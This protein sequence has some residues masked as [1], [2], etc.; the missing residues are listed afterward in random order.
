[1]FETEERAPLQ[2]MWWLTVGA[3]CGSALMYLFDPSRGKRR[4]TM[5]RDRAVH[6]GHVAADSGRRPLRRVVH[7]IRGLYMKLISPKQIETDDDTLNCRVRSEFGRKISH[8]SAIESRVRNGV[9]TLRGPI[10]EAEVAGLL[11][12]VEHVPGIMGIVNQLEV[13]GTS[14]NVPGLQ[15]FRPR[16]QV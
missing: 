11:A 1:M 6:L 13:H 5:I 2:R 12:C 8:A 16:V 4:R 7:K 10:L 3:V 9:V 15:G 14:E